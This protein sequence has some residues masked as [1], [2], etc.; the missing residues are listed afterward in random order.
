MSLNN[1]AL[2]IDAQGNARNEQGQIIG[3]LESGPDNALDFQDKGGT[4]IITDGWDA[5]RF[6]LSVRYRVQERAITREV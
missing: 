1:R 4:W 3:T 6:E 5:M 2:A